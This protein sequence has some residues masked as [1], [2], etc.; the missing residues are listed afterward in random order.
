MKKFISG[1]VLGFILATMTTVFAVSQI[2]AYFNPD[3]KIN[4]NGTPLKTEIVS[5]DETQKNYVSVRDVA[6]ALGA[7][8]TWDQKTKTIDITSKESE[9]DTVSTV[10]EK[11]T[12]TTEYNSE[13][14]LPT[15][16]EWVDFNGCKA[17]KYNNNIYILDIDLT[18][19]LGFYFKDYN[20]KTI[21]TYSKD[22]RDV[23]I[24]ISNKNNYL[25]VNSRFYLNYQLFDEIL[26]E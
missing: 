24:D 4:I 25:K 15:G 10:T 18:E 9:V 14:G 20:N 26:G 16:A 2:T 11:V 19:R 7:T 12:N 22:G 5:V 23:I 21:L 6:E 13:T 1:L 8:V 17:I 3:I